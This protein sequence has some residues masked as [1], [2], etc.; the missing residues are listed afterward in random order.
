MKSMVRRY[1][2]DRR[3]IILAVGPANVDIATQEILCVSLLNYLID[4]ST[5]DGYV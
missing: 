2:K 1:I 4:L 5:P 3:T